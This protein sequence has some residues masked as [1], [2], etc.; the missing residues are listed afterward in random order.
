MPYQVT[1]PIFEGPLDLLLHLI[2]VQ[3]ID[4]YDIPIAQITTQYLAYLDLME[5]LNLDVAGEWLVM[6]ATLTYIKSRMLLPRPPE[7]AEDDEED[8]RHELVERLLEYQWVKTLALELRER[9]LDQREVYGRPPAEAPES[10]EIILDVTLFDLLEAFSAV[11]ERL[12][13]EEAQDLVI[14]EMSVTEMIH[15]LVERLEGKGPIAFEAL[16]DEA[17]SRP[18]IIVTFL[19]ILEMMRLKML[20]V[21]QRQP[22]GSL[23]LSLAVTEEEPAWR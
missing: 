9:E 11:L 16:F 22:F 19:A 4:I 23:R 6:A 17:T 1:L 18:E 2:R 7:A 14:E 12:P 3:E 21:Q 15:T 8:P 10:D 5:A 13:A 20:Y